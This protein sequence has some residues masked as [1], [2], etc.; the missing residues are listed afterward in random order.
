MKGT[1]YQNATASAYVACTYACVV[2]VKPALAGTSRLLL[3]FWPLG[4]NK[5]RNDLSVSSTRRLDAVLTLRSC[6]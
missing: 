3:G 2:R 5:Q 1:N 4:A 6:L